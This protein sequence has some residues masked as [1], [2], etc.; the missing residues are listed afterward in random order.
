MALAH[1]HLTFVLITISERHHS[2]LRRH[3]VVDKRAPVSASIL[4]Y[5][6]AQA[7]ESIIIE[8]PNIENAVLDIEEPVSA[9]TTHL[10]VLEKSIVFIGS[11]EHA[12][13]PTGALT[14][15]EFPNILNPKFLTF[16]DA[17]LA[18]RFGFF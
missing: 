3:R 15:F 10:V 11:F 13:T 8:L 2:S 14:L 1:F 6:L 17:S 7:L 5:H 18:F 16:G 12:C 9:T 4:E